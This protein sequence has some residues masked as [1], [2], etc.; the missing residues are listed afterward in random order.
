MCCGHAL[1]PRFISDILNIIQSAYF[2]PRNAARRMS[3][4]E[5]HDELVRRLIEK[6]H[7]EH[8]HHTS[9]IDDHV[10]RNHHT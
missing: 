3:N 2:S 7:E 9:S 5:S 10:R 4:E 8:S 1:G 6:A